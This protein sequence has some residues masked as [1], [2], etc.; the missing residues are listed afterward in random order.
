MGFVNLSIYRQNTSKRVS[1]PK[2]I[3]DLIQGPSKLKKQKIF[4]PQN[5]D[6]FTLP[7]KFGTKMKSLTPIIWPSAT[8]YMSYISIAKNGV[9]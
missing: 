9:N 3:Y 6:F 2:K 4:G 1:G 5:L 8:R 7:F